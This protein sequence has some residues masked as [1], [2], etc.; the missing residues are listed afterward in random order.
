MH[1]GILSR[2]LSRAVAT[3]LL[4]PFVCMTIAACCS[5]PPRLE[6]AKDSLKL[7]PPESLGASRSARQRLHGS[8]AEREETLQCVV[9]V[10]P[11]HISLVALSA[12]GTRIFSLGYDGRKLDAAISPLAALQLKPERILSDM[13]LALWPLASLQQALVGSA[14][15]INEPVAGTRRLRHG[16]RLI[17][18][19]H[20]SGTDPW[21]GRFWLSN[22]EFGY[23]LM[24]ESTGLQ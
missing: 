19:V 6:P 7:L 17:A 11:G 15:K 5:S 8:F 16:G 3:W 14:W 24:V 9:A 21:R 1:Y 23:S 10:D 13:Q 12:T 22:F 18:E 2:H 4:V 20:Y